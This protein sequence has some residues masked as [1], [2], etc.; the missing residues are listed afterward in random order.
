[1]P[2]FSGSYTF[3]KTLEHKAKQGL[4]VGKEVTVVPPSE[5]RER[6]TTAMDNY[7][8]ACPGS[9]VLAMVSA[10]RLT[11]SPVDK[12]SKPLDELQCGGD[13]HQLPSVL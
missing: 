6:F 7:F 5:Y 9:C 13:P 8:L 1:M 11:L 4:N 10:R 12:W 3:A 2:Y